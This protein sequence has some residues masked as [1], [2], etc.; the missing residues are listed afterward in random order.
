MKKFLMATTV[1]L[2]MGTTLK[3]GG[4]NKNFTPPN[5]AYPTKEIGK[6]MSF[7]L[8]QMKN[9]AAKNNQYEYANNLVG[10]IVTNERICSCIMDSYRENQPYQ[11]FLYEFTKQGTA[12]DVP[13]FSSY[14]AGCVQHS[15][16]VI[17]TEDGA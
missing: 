12:K 14:F 17:I 16:N 1:F 13:L 8:G 6:F 15:N 5:I 2:L 4:H 10:V 9:L 11:T 7:C 3:A